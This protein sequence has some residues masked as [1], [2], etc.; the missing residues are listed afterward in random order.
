MLWIGEQQDMLA[1]KMVDSSQILETMRS[2]FE[3]FPYYLICLIVLKGYCPRHGVLCIYWL[4]CFR[5]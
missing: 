5:V 4:M 1:R 3:K 2:Y